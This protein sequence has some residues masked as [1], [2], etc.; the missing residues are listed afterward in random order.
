[1]HRGPDTDQ[2]SDDEAAVVEVPP[3]PNRGR[4]IGA[5]LA[6][7]TLAAGIA[8]AVSRP[9]DGRT[10]I[11]QA[12]TAAPTEDTVL[13]TTT[14]AAA[15]PAAAPAEATASSP[16]PACPAAA[17]QPPGPRL[18]AVTAGTPSGLVVFGGRDGESQDHNDTWAFGCGAWARPM[19]AGSPQ[20]P[21][22]FNG[23]AAYDP[24]RGNTVL[25]V[26]EKAGSTTWLWNGH[27]WAQKRTATSPPWFMSPVAAF[28]DVH[29]KVLVAGHLMM[30]DFEVWAWDGTNWSAVPNPPPV[31]AGVAFAFDSARRGAVLFGGTAELGKYFDDTWTWD[32]QTWTKRTPAHSPPAGSATA[33]YD[34]VHR[35]VVLLATDGTTWTWDG[36]DWTKRTP[37]TSP[38]S[39]GYTQLTWDPSRQRVMLFGGKTFDAMVGDLW[40][41][42]GTDWSKIG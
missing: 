1:M 7:V 41:W 33:A 39:R 22:S 15:A 29:G 28:D 16:A 11:R 40:A 34:P 8:F 35:H 3:A 38:G 10:D 27:A 9:S 37:A 13:S 23:A 12:G 21:A 2:P 25:L 30:G 24:V 31:A 20:P 6:A 26:S 18:G 5:V 36:S 42:D 32:G 17:A 19:D 4:V 14:T